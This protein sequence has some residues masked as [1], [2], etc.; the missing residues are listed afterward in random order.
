M[1]IEEIKKILNVELYK[2]FVEPFVGSSIQS[3]VFKDEERI[4]S[5]I[6][7]D[8]K[9]IKNPVVLIKQYIERLKINHNINN[10]DIGKI[11][12]IKDLNSFLKN[13]DLGKEKLCRLM[14]CLKLSMDES[15]EILNSCSKIIN[16]KHSVFDC[17]YNCYIKYYDNEQ[18]SKKVV[19]EFDS[20][21]IDSNKYINDSIRESKLQL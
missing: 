3:T 21:V 11:I 13:D 10:E 14:I 2:N 7:N 5:Y 15:S 20:L 16:P 17:V 1:K 4:M 18:P 9:K 12:G 6:K 19:D 8:V